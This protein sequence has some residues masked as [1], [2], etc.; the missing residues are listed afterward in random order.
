[1]SKTDSLEELVAD[2]A[3]FFFLCLTS[4]VGKE[5]GLSLTSASRVRVGV[6]NLMF[7]DRPASGLGKHLNV[8]PGFGLL[9]FIRSVIKNDPSSERRN[10]GN[11]MLERKA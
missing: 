7:E 5:Q 8:A 4:V 11:P 1:V 10:S 6:T 3:K 2:L 9:H